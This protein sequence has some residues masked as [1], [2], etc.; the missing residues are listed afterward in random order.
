MKKLFC[1]VT[2]LVFVFAFVSCSAGVSIPYRTIQLANRY[3]EI[4][5]ET[6]GIAA[7]RETLDYG[8]YSYSVYY[9][10]VYNG[11]LLTYN[12]AETAPDYALYARNG[13]IFIEKNG[14]KYA[15]LQISGTYSDF[16][17]KYAEYDHPLD[18]GSHYQVRSEKR[19]DGGYD[20]TYKA[21]ITPQTEGELADYEVKLGA[22]IFSRHIIDGN[23]LCES[24]EYFTGKSE[25]ERFLLKRT[26]EYYTEPQNI[27]GDVPESDVKVK[28]IYSGTRS[29]EF[30]VPA[31]YFIGFDMPDVSYDF[32]RDADFTEAFDAEDVS[33][34]ENITLYVRARGKNG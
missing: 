22:Y 33:I 32:F 29:A 23:N 13:R 11:K 16:V 31:G 8:D 26:F 21:Q 3:S 27:F 10:K 1:L 34:T 7:F 28:I 12:I 25:G 4:F 15:L 30:S 19:T 24:V 5:S 18:A 6:S 17:G 9:E 14:K 20:V 2:A